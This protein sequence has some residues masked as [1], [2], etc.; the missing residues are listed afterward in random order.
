ML[1]KRPWGVT[2]LG[3]GFSITSILNMIVLLDIKNYYFLFQSWPGEFIP[4][5]FA[6]SWITRLLGLASGVGL[7]C[8]QEW[9]RKMVCGLAWFAI[10]VVYWKHPYDAF[11]RHTEHLNEYFDFSQL[12]VSLEFLAFTSCILA[13]II[14]VCWASATL[15]YLSRKRVKDY[16]VYYR[17]YASSPQANHQ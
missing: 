7:L 17:V 16:F 14:E 15:Y 5:R 10:L 3:A 2:I 9:A 1:P 13:R 12:G 6:I 4:L 8:R 11:L